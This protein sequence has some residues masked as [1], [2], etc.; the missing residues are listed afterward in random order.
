MSSTWR[1]RARSGCW[2]HV[3]ISVRVGGRAGRSASAV[4]AGSPVGGGVVAAQR[5]HSRAETGMQQPGRP[6]R[7]AAGC[8]PAGRTAGA[9]TGRQRGSARAARRSRWP[10]AEQVLGE[11][12]HGG[13][14]VL[15]EVV[16]LEAA[17]LELTLVVAGH[18]DQPEPVPGQDAGQPLQLPVVHPH[19]QLVRGR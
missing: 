9:R 18:G 19:Q 2:S 17:V 14:Q 11:H 6:R 15:E 16:D 7:A 12:D 5:M 1:P 4:A 3:L 10:P 13:M 8:S